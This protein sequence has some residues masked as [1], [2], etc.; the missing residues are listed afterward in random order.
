[1]TKSRKTKSKNKDFQKVKLKIGKKLPKGQNETIATFKSTSIQIKEQLRKKDTSQPVTK[2]KLNIQEL[3]VHCLHY[4]TT[5]RSEAVQGILEL[6]KTSSSVLDNNLSVIIERTSAMI[7]DKEYSVRQKAIQVIKHIFS[8]LS[9]SQITPFFPLIS[10]HITCAMTHLAEPIQQ[11]SLEVVDLCLDA[12]PELMNASATKLL[13]CFVKQIASP[14]GKSGRQYTLVTNPSSKKSS[15]SWR[16]R[17]LQRLQRVLHSFAVGHHVDTN[18]DTTEKCVPS[19]CTSKSTVSMQGSSA[20]TAKSMS[21]ITFSLSNQGANSEEQADMRVFISEITPLLSQCWIESRPTNFTPGS[22]LGLET[23]NLVDTILSIYQLF[24]NYLKE[25]QLFEKEITQYFLPYFPYTMQRRKADNKGKQTALSPEVINL[26]LCNLLS[27]PSD[28]SRK[29]VPVWLS[30]VV[31]YL[32]RS[33][34]SSSSQH[35][36][37]VHSVIKSLLRKWPQQSRSLLEKALQ[38]FVSCTQVDDMKGWMKFLFDVA[39]STSVVLSESLQSIITEWVLTLP[40]ML[41]K[42]ESES[43]HL[44]TPILIAI[45]Q[46]ALRGTTQIGGK[47]EEVMSKLLAASFWNPDRKV[48]LVHLVNLLALNPVLQQKDLPQLKAILL[49]YPDLCVRYLEH[50]SLHHTKCKQA[51]YISLLFALLQ[52]KKEDCNFDCAFSGQCT[53][54]IQLQVGRNIRAFGKDLDQLKELHMEYHRML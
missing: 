47:V 12:C 18:T 31:A 49:A 1:M 46:A 45:N 3:L 48:D 30:T 28:N 15:Q 33:L 16:L 14:G 9:P 36:N 44:I 10:A 34:T 50:L 21:C 11:D 32:E 41:L 39:F 52:C 2:K 53:S 26:R 5:V 51:L 4:S 43:K 17:V 6:L 38:C 19:D 8:V 29:K 13:P 20:F 37:L 35:R 7:M 22:S 24:R 27:A 23:L 25:D 54:V 42:V 40:K